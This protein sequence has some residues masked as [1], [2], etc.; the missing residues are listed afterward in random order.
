M[1]RSHTPAIK[2]VEE[3]IKDIRIAKKSRCERCNREL[4]FIIDRDDPD[5]YFITDII[6][7]NYQLNI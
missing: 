1:Y 2:D 3:Y 7:Y 6:N 4:L 5:C